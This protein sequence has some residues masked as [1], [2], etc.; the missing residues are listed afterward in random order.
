MR[1]A[2]GAFVKAR[3]HMP[4]LPMPAAHLRSAALCVEGAMFRHGEPVARSLLE[5]SMSCTPRR[6]LLFLAMTALWSSSSLV[7]CSDDKEIQP[8]IDACPE[9]QV[10][11][12]DRCEPPET[13]TPIH[14]ECLAIATSDWTQG[15]LAVY[16]ITNGVVSTDVVT[17]YSDTVLATWGDQILAL[18]RFGADTLQALDPAQGFSPQ[19]TLALPANSNPAT[20]VVEGDRA[21]V[22]L[23]NSAEVVEIA[24]DAAD[25]EKLTGRSLSIPTAGEWDGSQADIG[26]LLVHDGKLFVLN[27]AIGDDWK[28]AADAKAALV[29]FDLETLAPAPI[30]EDDANSLLLSTCNGESM[31]AIGDN[32][33]IQTVGVYR[34][35]AD[36]EPTN[37]GG[38]EVVNLSTGT[39]EAQLVSEDTVGGRDISKIGRVEGQDALWA[40]FPGAEDFNAGDLRIIETDGSV[41]API[42]NGYLFDAIVVGE[43]IIAASQDAV[44][45]GIHQVHLQDLDS[46]GVL[47]TGLAPVSLARFS[48]EAATCF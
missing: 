4:S 27:Q 14:A 34:A 7:A 8:P 11:V 41:S 45:P 36:G 2:Y 25:D 47:S 18:N 20:L 21:F 12:D 24:L 46:S 42:L 17:L 43:D 22:A 13:P 5:T 9:D 48:V 40:I 28:C 33:Y 19:W 32:L 6:P 35:W 31:V 10:W 30:F 15:Q 29:A 3:A 38:I 16:D 1:P 26:E 44:E 37:D 23:L 39:L